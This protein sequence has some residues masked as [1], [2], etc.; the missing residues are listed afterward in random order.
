MRSKDIKE[1]IPGKYVLD[2]IS[3]ATKQSQPISVCIQIWETEIYN[4]FIN[5]QADHN[6]ISTQTDNNLSVQLYS[7]LAP[8]IINRN[9]KK[10]R[11]LKRQRST[12]IQQIASYKRN[13]QN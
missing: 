11:H 1:S 12:E 6:Q 13:P 8:A 4:C 5:Q 9:H 3:Q 7:Q 10:V 2:Q